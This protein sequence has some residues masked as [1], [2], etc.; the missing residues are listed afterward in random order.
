VSLLGD[1]YG[2]NNSWAIKLPAKS[3]YL[4]GTLVA[5]EVAGDHHGTKDIHHSSCAGGA[6]SRAGYR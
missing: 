1:F 2:K 6:H 3:P 4:I 5:I